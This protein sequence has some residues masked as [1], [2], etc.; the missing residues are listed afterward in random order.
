MLGRTAGAVACP[1]GAGSLT[2]GADGLATGWLCGVASASLLLAS[3]TAGTVTASASLLIA[4]MDVS[5]V[6]VSESAPSLLMESSVPF[7]F[8][9]LSDDIVF[10]SH[11]SAKA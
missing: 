9:E 1:T 4:G 6:V 11:S 3:G 5:T 2:V 8:G 7:F 10:K